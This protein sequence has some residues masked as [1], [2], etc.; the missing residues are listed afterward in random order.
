M[1]ARKKAKKKHLRIT[2]VKSAIGYRE[3]QKRT[4]RALGLRRLNQSVLH[5]DNPVIR[6][7]VFKV[8]HLLRVE[9]VEA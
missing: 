6:G 2:W 3:D 4:V 9:E 8:Q 7:M 5:E 1:A